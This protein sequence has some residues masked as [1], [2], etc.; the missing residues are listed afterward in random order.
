MEANTEKHRLDRK[1]DTKTPEYRAERAKA[2]KLACREEVVKKDVIA[3]DESTELQFKDEEASRNWEQWVKA[4][5]KDEYS[6]AV[7]TYARRFGKYMQHLMEKHNKTVVDIAKNASYV[8]NIDGITKF[9]Y[10]CAV[11][12][13]AQCWKYGEELRKW[14]N[15][16][17]GQ[18]APDAVVNPALL[19]I[20]TN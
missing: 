5:S 9:M 16:E 4:N 19:A 1:V 7:V 3:V 13:L 12:I 8:S 6:L 17:W 10:G 20:A 11:S 2:L 14:H 15:K 18:E